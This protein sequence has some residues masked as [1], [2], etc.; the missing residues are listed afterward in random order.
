[1]EERKGI[2]EENTIELQDVCKMFE[3]ETI[4][5]NVNLICKKGS[6]TGII[7]RNGSGK[8]VLFKCICGFLKLEQ[9]EIYIHGMNIKEKK[10]NSGKIGAIIETPAFLEQYSGLKNLELLY[11]IRNKWDRNHI[12]EIMH[13]VGLDPDSRKVV[14]KYSMGMKQRLAIAQAIMEE[15]DILIMDEPM[16][17]LDNRGVDEICELFTALKEEGKTILMSSHNK[18]DIQRLCEQVFEMDDVI[19]RKI[20]G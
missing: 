19:L 5:K 2:E 15:Q 10:Y 13:Q 1:M 12:R 18:E 7:G 9:G 6:I 17:G 8:T 20:R 14:G 16:N 11:C 3:K 4:L